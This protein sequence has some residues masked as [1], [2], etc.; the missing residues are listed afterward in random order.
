[1]SKKKK[2]QKVKKVIQEV[3]RLGK[4]LRCG[5]PMVKNHK[6]CI[7]CRRKTKLIKKANRRGKPKNHYLN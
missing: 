1:M 7:A 5:K 6:S 3:E 2:E 4:C